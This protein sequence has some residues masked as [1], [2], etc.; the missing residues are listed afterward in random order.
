MPES[1]SRCTQC[2]DNR[3]PWVMKNERI[4]FKAFKVRIVKADEE[5]GGEN[6]QA[7]FDVWHIFSPSSLLQFHPLPRYN[8]ILRRIKRPS[9][10]FLA[11]HAAIMHAAACIHRF[12]LRIER[13]TGYP[14]IGYRDTQFHITPLAQSAIFSRPFS[15]FLCPSLGIARINMHKMLMGEEYARERKRKREKEM[16]AVWYFVL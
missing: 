5:E 2:S 4:N 10:F 9:S 8:W 7:R 3:D 6:N 1:R 15:T 14:F 12:Q 13:L 16:C 11:L